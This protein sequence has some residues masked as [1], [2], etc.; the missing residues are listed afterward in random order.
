MSKELTTGKQ[1]MWLKRAICFETRKAV[2]ERRTSDPF[3]FALDLVKIARIETSLGIKAVPSDALDTIEAALSSLRL[4]QQRPHRSQSPEPPSPDLP[5]P[6][7]NL[8][9]SQGSSHESD[10]QHP[11]H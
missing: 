11:T 3:S 2:L 6:L 9:A 10:Q 7:R 4:S 1:V 5:A 8:S